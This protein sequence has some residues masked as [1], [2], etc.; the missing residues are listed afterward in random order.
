MKKTTT[1]LFL[2]KLLLA[3]CCIPAALAVG[4]PFGNTNGPPAEIKV[5]NHATGPA[6]IADSEVR[7]AQAQFYR[8]IAAE[9]ASTQ[10]LAVPKDWVIATS[11]TSGVTY[12]QTRAIKDDGGGGRRC[13]PFTVIDQYRVANTVDPAVGPAAVISAIVT[14]TTKPALITRYQGLSGVDQDEGMFAK[15]EALST[16]PA[17]E[18]VAA[19]TIV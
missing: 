16:A 17:N 1:G 19:P 3:C 12:T 9:F 11:D 7:L 10:V 2:W 4:V 6:T 5:T 8:L 13:L 14:C 18:E 15:C